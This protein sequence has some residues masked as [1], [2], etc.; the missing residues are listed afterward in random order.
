[1]AEVTINTPDLDSLGMV[2]DFG[3]L[4]DVMN[5]FILESL[6]HNA[7]LNKDDPSLHYFENYEERKPYIMKYGNP[8]AENIAREI[9][10]KA[11]ELLPKEMIVV[12]V[13]VYETPNCYADYT[14]G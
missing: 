1:M 5:T 11:E 8:T 12:N 3:V 7:I 9:F 6:D 4:K 10:E 13:R 14:K 2:I